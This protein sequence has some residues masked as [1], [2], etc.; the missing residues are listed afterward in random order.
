MA[1]LEA[2]LKKEISTNQLYS[3]NK[4]LKDFASIFPKPKLRCSFEK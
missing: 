3:T 2:V 1:N 4:S